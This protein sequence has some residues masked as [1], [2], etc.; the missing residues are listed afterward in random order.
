M[1]DRRAKPNIL[2]SILTEKLGLPEERHTVKAE[3]FGAVLTRCRKIYQKMKH[4]ENFG[5]VLVR[6]PGK[7]VYRKFPST[8]PP[9]SENTENITPPKISAMTAPEEHHTGSNLT[10]LI[11]LTSGQDEGGL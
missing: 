10:V 9:I 4:T 5:T 11:E 7:R 2:Q 3:I 1:T 6:L 8:K